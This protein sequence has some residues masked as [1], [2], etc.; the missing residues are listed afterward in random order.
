MAEEAKEHVEEGDGGAL[1][2]WERVELA[3]EGEMRR[4]R[5]ASEAVGRLAKD[6]GVTGWETAAVVVVVMEWLDWG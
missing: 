4:E 1:G 3:G 5:E 2:V 6:L